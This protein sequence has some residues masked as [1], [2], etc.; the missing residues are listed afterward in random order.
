[1]A[2]RGGG[3]TVD[4][5]PEL[6]EVVGVFMAGGAGA[7]A[8]LLLSAALDERAFR[9]PHV[10]TLTVNLLGCFAIGLVAA[11]VPRGP[12][13][14]VL[15]TGLLGGFTT[16]STFALLTYESATT[17][18]WAVVALQ[19]AAHLVGGVLAVALGWWC[20]GLCGPTS[21]R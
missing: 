9:L 7:A 3:D 2:T 18:R 10:G 14:T 20:G 16:Y 19:C 1:L 17:G 8:R 5:V 13:R 12:W 15:A 4:G 21:L 6:R 11:A